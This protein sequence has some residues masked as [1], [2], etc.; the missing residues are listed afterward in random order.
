MI[1]HF[2]D[3]CH[4]EIKGEPVH[5]SLARKGAPGSGVLLTTYDKEICKDCGQAIKGTIKSIRKEWK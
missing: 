3:L 2:C 1:K 5:F 4:R